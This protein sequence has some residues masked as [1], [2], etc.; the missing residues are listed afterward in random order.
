MTVVNPTQ[1]SP[2]DTI[3]A[4]DVNTPVNQLAAVLNGNVDST[5]LADN[6]VAT[7]KIA[8]SA[9]TP[10]KL[11]TG[12]GSSWVWQTWSPTLTGFSVNPPN[13]SYSYAQVGKSVMLNI[14]A[15]GGTSNSN[16][17][18]FTLPVAA[19]TRTNNVVNAWCR[20]QDNGVI[21]TNPGLVE[22][23]SAATVATVYKDHS[24]GAWTAS[25][26]KGFRCTFVYEVA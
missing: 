15:L 9:V 25:G 12:T 3:E 19:A 21:G 10:A 13:A 5:N 26:T 11:L 20:A 1:S 24:G 16:A 23:S 2:G 14:A 6:A 4:A 8:D 17:V 18:T 7:A 22:F